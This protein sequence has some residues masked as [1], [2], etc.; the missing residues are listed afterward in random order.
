MEPLP[1]A[2][3][4]IE[5]NAIVTIESNGQ[6]TTGPCPVLIPQTEV[7]TEQVI[8]G[9]ARAFMT[10][11]SGDN[12]CTSNDTEC[13]LQVLY[14]GLG[15]PPCPSPVVTMSADPDD[16]HNPPVTFFEDTS[17]SPTIPGYPGDGVALEEIAH[18]TAF[19]F[20]LSPDQPDNVSRLFFLT[21]VCADET[22]NPVV[23]PIALGIGGAC[24]PETDI[25]GERYDGLLGVDSPVD[26]ALVAQGNPVNFSAGNF[27]HGS[28][29]PMKVDLFCGSQLLVDADIDPNPVI[30]SLVLCQDG[31]ACTAQV[32]QTL[33]GIN[34][35]NNANPDDPLFNCTD[36]GCNYKYRTAAKP[37]G[38]FVVAIQMPDGRVFEVGFT[39]S[40]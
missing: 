29:I 10:D 38:T 24:D 23:M 18:D 7:N 16:P 11:S 20:A 33:E 13:I 8:V 15:D 19:R 39:V 28:T 37:S 14:S 36:A 40:P 3:V 32:P 26:A 17:T 34:G 5:Q 12:L 27:N 2:R 21:F 22:D 6:T 30:V 31:P 9:P 1:E 25:D 4:F 35:D